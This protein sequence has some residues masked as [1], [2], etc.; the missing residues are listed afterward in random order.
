MQQFCDK[1][2]TFVDDIPLNYFSYQHRYKFIDLTSENLTKLEEPHLVTMETNG[3]PF[4]LYLI[5]IKGKKYCIM[6]DEKLKQCISVKFRF[7]QELYKGTVFKGDL[8]KNEHNQWFFYIHDLTYYKGEICMKSL[9]QRLRLI[10]DIL[11]NQYKWDEYMNICQLKI[12][13]YFLYE[14]LEKIEKNNL[15]YFYPE[16]GNKVYK[17]SSEQS[18]KTTQHQK[19]KMILATL[20]KTQKP[21][22]Y[23]VYYE[24]ELLGNALIR[25][26]KLSK[27]LFHLFKKKEKFDIECKYNEKF[28][29]WEPIKWSEHS[30]GHSQVE[31][32]EPVFEVPESVLEESP[33]QV[34]ELE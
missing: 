6:Y 33:E 27:D 13:S 18:N 4:S 2:A 26:L 28:Q 14:H 16:K 12:R 30:S 23:E 11:K 3:I 15:V 22:V 25:S 29:K 1:K 17:W 34:Q 31:V 19:N 7:N 24:G 21:D 8:R 5:T 10:Y 32:E 20:Y 9:S